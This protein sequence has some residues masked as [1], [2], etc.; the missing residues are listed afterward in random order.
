MYK[1]LITEQFRRSSLMTV[2]QIMS[3]KHND[4]KKFD[5]GRNFCQS[6]NLAIYSRRTPV[7]L[8]TAAATNFNL[9]Q[10]TNKTAEIIKKPHRKRKGRNGGRQRRRMDGA[11]GVASA[12]KGFFPFSKTREKMTAIKAISM[13]VRGWSFLTLPGQVAAARQ[14][15]LEGKKKQS[16][17]VLWVVIIIHE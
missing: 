17:N 11:R 9:C 16:K 8:L 15:K 12:L 7:T 6:K 5:H 1:I 14:K 4:C 13:N 10:E 3:K 2:A